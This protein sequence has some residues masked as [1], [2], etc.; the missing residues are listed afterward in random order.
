MGEGAL[1]RGALYLVATPIGNLGDLSPR[2]L[3]V[4]R[5][6]DWIAAEDTRHTKGLLARFAVKT[7]L[8]SAHAH[9]ERARAGEVVARLLAGEVGALVVDAGSPGVSDPGERI[10]RAVIEAGRPVRVVPG[11][12]AVIAALSLS[13]LP[14]DAFTF[15]GFLSARAGARDARL[16]ELLARRETLVV[17]EAPHRVRAT[18]EAIARLAPGRPLAACRELTKLHEE[19][20][21]GD[22][23]AVLAQLTEERERGEWVL[24]VAGAKGAAPDAAA[25]SA[26][27]AEDAARARFVAEQVASGAS[28]EEARRRAAFVLGP[29]GTGRPK[30]GRGSRKP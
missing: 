21:R 12:S 10:V 2:A 23:S 5:A 14:T 28:P 17:Y 29:P 6:V 11:P 26:P 20:L 16:A 15:A 1:E 18:L 27:P 22:A 13:G 25:A 19:V 4:L 3:D 9:N 8:F 30:S 24:V 7:P